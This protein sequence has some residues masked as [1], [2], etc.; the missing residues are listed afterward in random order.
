M[1]VLFLLC[2]CFS[3]PCC[4]CN[5]YVNTRE[6]CVRNVKINACAVMLSAFVPI[7]VSANAVETPR[8]CVST[9]KKRSFTS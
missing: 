9:Y 7:S 6:M 8:K 2:I 4:P 5:L 1:N 3:F